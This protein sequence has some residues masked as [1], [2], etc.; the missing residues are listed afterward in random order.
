MI[1]F[2]YKNVWYRRQ[3]STGSAGKSEVAPEQLPMISPI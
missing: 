1:D 3:M 2:D